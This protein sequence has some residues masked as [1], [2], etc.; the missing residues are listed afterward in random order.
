[1]NRRE[2]LKMLGAAGLASATGIASAKVPLHSAHSAGQ[3]RAKKPL[4]I[5]FLTDFHLPT[6][7]KDDQFK[8]VM[9]KLEQEGFPDLLLFGGDNILAANN[10]TIRSAF[11]QLEHW[12]ELVA[13]KVHVPHFSVMGNHDIWGVDTK[14]PQKRLL[15]KPMAQKAFGMPNRFYSFKFG[16]WKFIA[17]DT[18]HP[19]GRDY[20]GKVDAE[21]LIW[22]REELS[23]S[24]EPTL[25]LG[26][27]PIL[28]VCP[29][30]NPQTARAGH[31]TRVG[32]DRILENGYEVAD[33]IRQNPHVRL[34]LSGHIH[35]VDHVKV[36]HTHYVCGGAVS[37]A[38]WKGPYL[39]FK[40]SIN[41]VELHSSGRVAV[42]QVEWEI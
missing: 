38:W 11:N 27:V 26:H 3:K 17:L 39:H 12:E 14:D 41:I 33:I 19:G 31:S 7:G 40:P 42:K 15:G 18:V 13:K 29:L 9:A 23:K 4:K 8:Q 16:E 24:S 37:G 6:S 32:H 1:M 30:I 25:L 22:L 36:H 28:S 34:S 10:A 20:V 2:L 5:G 35:M 21:Q